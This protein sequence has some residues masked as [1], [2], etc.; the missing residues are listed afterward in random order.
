LV[1]PASAAVRKISFTSSVNA[2]D[3][4]ALTVSVSPRARCTIKVAYDT[5]VSHA[6]GLGPKTGTRITWRWKV[7][8]NTHAGSWPVTVDC[9]KSGRLALRLHVR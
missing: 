3:E 5:T 4:A 9:G 6:Q 8:S 2:N 1:A 7:G